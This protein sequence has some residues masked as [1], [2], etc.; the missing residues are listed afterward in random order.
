MKPDREKLLDEVLGESSS[1]GFKESLLQHTLQEVHRRKRVR[2]LNRAVLAV[3]IVAA[4]PLMVWKF[5]APSP[6]LVVPPPPFGIVTTQPLPREMLVETR[7][8]SV[9]FI[10]SSTASVAYVRTGDAKNLFQEINDEQLLSLLAGRP[11]A[12]VRSGPKQA[13]LIFLHPG[14]E[15]G[16]RVP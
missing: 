12:L 16:F 1:P 13:E 15:Q 9:A 14:D 6:V 5:S 7:P 10:A 4:V 8:G 2:R 11:A 3:A